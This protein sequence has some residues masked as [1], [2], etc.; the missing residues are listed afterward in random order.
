MTATEIPHQASVANSNSERF[1]FKRV[2]LFSDFCEAINIRQEVF[3]VEQKCPI[4]TEPDEVDHKCLQ[5]LVIDT[6]HPDHPGVPVPVATARLR[7]L[8]STRMAPGRIA[9]LK[10]H[11]GLGLGK[12]LVK[13]VE[14]GAKEEGYTESEMHAQS[15][16]RGFY[17][18]LGY[19]FMEGTKEFMEDGIPH[20]MMSKTL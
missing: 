14:Q 9:V 12:L 6:Q 20:I 16:K 11:R 19:A 1:Q 5:F 8:S 15:D 10:S 17:E 3:V 13:G 4:E 7:P 2:I 18:R